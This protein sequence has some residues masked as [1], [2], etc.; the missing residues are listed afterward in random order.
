MAAPERFCLFFVALLFFVPG[1]PLPSIKNGASHSLSFNHRFL[2]LLS[3][4]L[5][6]APD[7]Y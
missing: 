6:W 3:P 5:R 7:S 4:Q 2:M 1:L